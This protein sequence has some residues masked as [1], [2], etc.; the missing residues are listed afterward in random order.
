MQCHFVCFIEEVQHEQAM[1]SITLGWEW[2][3]GIHIRSK[4][5]LERERKKSFFENRMARNKQRNKEKSKPNANPFL[6][7]KYWHIARLQPEPERADVE[8]ATLL[9]SNSTIPHAGKGLF[10]TVDIKKGQRVIE[11]RGTAKLSDDKRTP[12]TADHQYCFAVTNRICIDAGD[13]LSSSAARYINDA[14]YKNPMARNTNPTRTNLDW[15]FSPKTL[16][17]WLVSTR[18]IPKDA[19]LF[20]EYGAEYWKHHG[21]LD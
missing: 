6:W 8:E 16:Q 20:V 3:C 12:H 13:P 1:N 11:Y 17:L 9:V 10:T 21:K 2:N 7:S 19:E 4:Q 15:H 5:N 14:T 18:D